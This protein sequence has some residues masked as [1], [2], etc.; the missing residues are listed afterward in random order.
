[1]IKFISLSSGSNGNCYYIGDDEK[2]ISLLIDFGIGG[3][4]V[5][6]RLAA[7]DIAADKV[8][9][10][11]ISH[12]HMDH[13]KYLGGFTEK[14]KKPI[15]TTKKVHN[16]LENNFCTKGHLCGCVKDIEVEKEY[17]CRGVRFTSFLVPH[18]AIETV[19][20]YI[21]F[22]GV[23]FTFITD[24]GYVT[25]DAVSYCRK[26]SNLII[27]S[28][29]DLDMLMSGSYTPELKV[30]IVQG[31]GHLSNEQSSSLLKRAYHEGLQNVFL[32]HLSQNNNTPQKAFECASEAL[33]SIG[34]NDVPVYCL[35]RSEASQVFSF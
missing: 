15:Y 16:A 17:E 14:F 18:D 26:S 32:C 9:F 6:K 27:E 12:N 11:L 5:K 31:H 20:Y 30:R 24:I 23:T 8:D 35:P 21:D 34:I 19:G 1:M 28:N 13:I 10:I 22:F 29:Y 3:R 4:T 2:N 25:D 33:R 7:F